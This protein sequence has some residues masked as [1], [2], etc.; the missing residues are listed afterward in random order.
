MIYVIPVDFL[1]FTSGIHKVTVAA[2]LA[3]V[4]LMSNAV[5]IFLTPKAKKVWAAAATF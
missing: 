3:I 1:L 2:A 5:T 4:F